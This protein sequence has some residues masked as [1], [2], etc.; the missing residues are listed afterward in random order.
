MPLVAPLQA[1][2]AAAWLASET[3]QVP[4]EAMRTDTRALALAA[5]EA[6]AAAEAARALLLLVS[7]AMVLFRS[8][9][10]AE[11]LGQAVCAADGSGMMPA[12][13]MEV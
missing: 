3:W 13:P 12:T 1:A 2:T 7:V 11:Q 6:E 9:M 5:A 10:V 4:R 8:V